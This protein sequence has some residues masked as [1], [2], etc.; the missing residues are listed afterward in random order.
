M[1][2][3]CN[4][5][6]TDECPS[7]KGCIHASPHEK[8]KGN[9]DFPAEC[10]DENGNFFKVRCIKTN[11]TEE[12]YFKQLEIKE[13]YDNG[14]GTTPEMWKYLSKL[15]DGEKLPQRM[16]DAIYLLC[17]GKAKIVKKK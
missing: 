2:V 5:A 12:E 15:L 14:L 6:N 7:K 11:M 10:Y 3:Q 8:I 9:C 16:N 17:E 4:K 1:L 13:F